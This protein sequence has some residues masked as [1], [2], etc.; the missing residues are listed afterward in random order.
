VYDPP[1]RR[2]GGYYTTLIRPGMRLISLN[3]QYCDM[4]NFYV[5]SSTRIDVAR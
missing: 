5:W 4:Y 2:Y 3:T 1:H